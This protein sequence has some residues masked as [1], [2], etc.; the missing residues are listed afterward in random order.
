MLVVSFRSIEATAVQASTWVGS[1][2]QF[3]TLKDRWITGLPQSVCAGIF[4]LKFAR[5]IYPN[6]LL[7]IQQVREVRAKGP[8]HWRQPPIIVELREKAK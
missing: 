6:E 4:T 8:S 5:S 1:A 2:K 7:H 3:E